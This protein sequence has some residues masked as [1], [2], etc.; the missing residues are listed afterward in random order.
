[1]INERN[2]KNV[3]KGLDK[4]LSKITLMRK[5]M[6]DSRSKIIRSLAVYTS[7]RLLQFTF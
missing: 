4:D 2:K 3:G 6:Q 5:I 7:S 1:M